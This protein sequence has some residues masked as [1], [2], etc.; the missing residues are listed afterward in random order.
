[1]TD[2]IQANDIRKIE[3]DTI[4]VGEGASV[5]GDILAPNM[6]VVDGSIEGSV[7]GHAIWVGPSGVIKG[8]V[9][10]DEAEIYGKISEKIEVKQ[11]LFVHTAGQ[12][13]GEIT[14]GELQLEKGA[15]LSGTLLHNELQSDKKEEPKPEQVL[16]KSERP[17]VLRLIEPG[18]LP[19]GNGAGLNVHLPVSD[20]RGI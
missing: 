7:I 8:K 14:Y 1:M 10:V 16:G 3:P 18:I 13:F 20:I 17:A 12:V 4:Y 19:N 2:K 6:L 9:V 5:K 15:I 11:L